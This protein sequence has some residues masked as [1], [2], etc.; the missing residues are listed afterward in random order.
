MK[1]GG[2]GHSQSGTRGNSKVGLKK[3]FKMASGPGTSG[4]KSAKSATEYDCG[5]AA[6]KGQPN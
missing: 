5:C 3:S 2:H 6:K 1:S 4:G